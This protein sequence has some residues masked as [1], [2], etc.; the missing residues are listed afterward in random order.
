MTTAATT[1][2]PWWSLACQEGQHRY[3]HGIWEGYS[4]L[5]ACY[6]HRLL[7]MILKKPEG[8]AKANG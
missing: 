2:N 5:C 4:Q 3:C 8:E 6:C 7:K 1:S